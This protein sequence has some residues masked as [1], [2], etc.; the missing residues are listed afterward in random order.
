MSAQFFKLAEVH[1]VRVCGI[2]DTKDHRVRVAYIESPGIFEA[3][4]GYT[5]MDDYSVGPG[6]LNGRELIALGRILTELGTA[7]LDGALIRDANRGDGS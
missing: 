7:M 6:R 2:T 4:N 1:N 5:E 3:R